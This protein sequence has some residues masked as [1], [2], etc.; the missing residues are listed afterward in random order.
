M[1]EI[2]KYLEI[3]SLGKNLSQEQAERAFQIVTSNGATPAQIAGLL[4]ALKTKGES[5]EEIYS[6]AKVL[7]SKMLAVNISNEKKQNT[8]DCCGTGGDGKGTLNI[9]TAVAFVLAASGLNVAKHGNRAV[10]S[11]SGSADVL[12]ALGINIDITAEQAGECL[13]QAGISFLFAP[14][15]HKS[16]VNIGPT[17]KELGVRTIFN[18]LGPLCNP[19][20]PPYQLI[21]VYA[22]ELTSKIA[23][24]AK[25]LGLKSA[26]IV[27]GEDGLD[28]ISISANTHASELKENGEIEDYI[29][30]PEDYGLNKHDESEILGKDPIYNSQAMNK[31]F[32]GEQSAYRDAVILNS[33]FALKI[34][35]KVKKVEDGLQLASTLIDTGKAKEKLKLLVE[36]TNSFA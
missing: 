20:T 22:P 29:I 1:A 25:M 26:I 35:G 34:A 6:A 28:E 9:S 14:L 16:L 15:F 17:R 19:A 33:A 8:I 36:V 30:N 24:V 12:K 27:S 4:L 11:K 3:V 18:I 5:E 2:S 31:L 23:E 13:D 10:S 21:G 7:R 32:S